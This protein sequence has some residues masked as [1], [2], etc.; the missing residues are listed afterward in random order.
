ML[1]GRRFETHVAAGS[2]ARVLSEM[3]EQRHADLIVLGSTHRGQHGRV[4]AGPVAERVLQNVPCPVAVA[5]RGFARH[6]HAGLGVIAVGYNGSDESKM[7]LREAERLASRL[8]A[9]LRLVAAVPPLA[10]GQAIYVPI[11]REHFGKA[12]TAAM[13]SLSTDDE[14][15]SVLLDGEPAA[16]LADQGLEADMLVIGSR[17]YGPL[18]RV[19][20]GGVSAAVMRTAPCPV[21]VVP[22]SSG[23]EQD[24]E[25][26]SRGDTAPAV[27]A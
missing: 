7:A 17:G 20:L 10:R 24:D 12:L 25:E 16:V 3:A 9:E 22:R 14:A 23:S 15:E 11:L 13:A 26:R 21:L 27:R 5:P 1:K 19:L 6:D 4:V 2:P 18:R 8:E